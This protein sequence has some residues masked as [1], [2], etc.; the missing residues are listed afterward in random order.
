MQLVSRDKIVFPPLQINL[1]HTKLFFKTLSINGDFI[2]YVY[3]SF[4]SLSSEKLKAGI[5]DGHQIRK[6]MKGK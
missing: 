3:S 4:P 5:Y 1:G 2:E 6:L